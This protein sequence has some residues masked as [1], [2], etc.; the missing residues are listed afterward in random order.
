MIRCLT[1]E[2]SNAAARRHISLF[3]LLGRGRGDPVASPG[4]RGCWRRARI[5]PGLLTPRHS[6]SR[7]GRGNERTSKAVTSR[8][9]L[10]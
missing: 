1:A 3:H 10:Q 9:C 7:R 8:G 2:S 5:G 4:P 6:W